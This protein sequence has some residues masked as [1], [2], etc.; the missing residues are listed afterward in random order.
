M[1]MTKLTILDILP[2]IKVVIPLAMLRTKE[3]NVALTQ[4]YLLAEVSFLSHKVQRMAI[5]R[6]TTARMKKT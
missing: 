5:G 2:E 3:T 4:Y 1:L 6:D